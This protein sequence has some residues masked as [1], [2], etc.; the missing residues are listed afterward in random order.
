MTVHHDRPHL[1]IT[2]PNLCLPVITGDVANQ[3]GVLLQANIRKAGT[4]GTPSVPRTTASSTIGTVIRAGSRRPS[5]HPLVICHPPSSVFAVIPPSS[6]SGVVR[7]SSLSCHP[8]VFAVSCA[9]H[10]P[11]CS[12]SLPTCQIFRTRSLPRRP[13]LSSIHHVTVAVTCQPPPL[14]AHRPLTGPA[15]AICEIF[16]TLPPVTPLIYSTSNSD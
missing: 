3:I 6:P 2:Y 4:V 16:P 5:C 14:A 9:T 12:P 8:P 10:P 13:V 15:P 11:L 7:A 1:D